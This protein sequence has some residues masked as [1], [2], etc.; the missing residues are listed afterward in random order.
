MQAREVIPGSS[1]K[2]K[3]VLSKADELF[4][5][6]SHGF[7]QFKGFKFKILSF[8]SV[9]PDVPS[10]VSGSHFFPVNALTFT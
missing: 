1:S 3:L 10:H 8:G 6:A 5:L 9:D 2:G 4:L 7:K